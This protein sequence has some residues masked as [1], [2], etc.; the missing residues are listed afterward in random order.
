MLVRRRSTSCCGTEACSNL[1][2]RTTKVPHLGFSCHHFDVQLLQALLCEGAS[3]HHAE[4]T[5]LDP[6]LAE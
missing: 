6:C 4:G 2:S 5:V 1:S 3:L